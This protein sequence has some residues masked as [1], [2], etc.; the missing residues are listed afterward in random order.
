MFPFP[1]PF[2]GL[3][4]TSHIGQEGT[5][6]VPH[7]YRNCPLS[8]SCPNCPFS[9]PCPRVLSSCHSSEISGVTFGQKQV[10]AELEMGRIVFEQSNGKRKEAGEVKFGDSVVKRAKKE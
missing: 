2:M 10:A 5:G 4:P 7:I 1:R 9:H 3:G 6:P 8:H